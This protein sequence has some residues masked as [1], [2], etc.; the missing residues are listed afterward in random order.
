[1]EMTSYYVEMSKHLAVFRT[2]KN[3][4]FPKG[5]YAWTRIRVSEFAHQGLLAEVK[6]AAVKR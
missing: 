6:R 5:T 4:V 1:M 2:V 3:E